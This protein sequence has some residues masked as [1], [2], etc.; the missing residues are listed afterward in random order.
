MR[1]TRAYPCLVC[2][3]LWMGMSGAVTSAQVPPVGEVEAPPAAVTSEVPPESAEERPTED[4]I[5]GDVSTSDLDEE[6]SSSSAEDGA[7]TGLELVDDMLT[8]GGQLYLRFDMSIL[9][10]QAFGEQAL[11][12]P[13]LLDIYL[14]ARPDPRLRAF[15]NGRLR[16]DPTVTDGEVDVAG[17]PIEPATVMLDQLWIKTDIERLVFFTIGQ[18]RVKWGACRVW[19]PTDFV[20]KSRRDPLTFFDERTGLPMI[21]LHV[22]FEDLGWNLYALML[23]D[24]VDS[25][26]DVG[27]AFR[28]EMVLGPAELSLS[29]VV[30]ANRKTSFGLDIS[31][32]VG[33]VDVFA[34]VA[35][36][37]EHGSND[38]V[39]DSGAAEALA[40]EGLTDAQFFQILTESVAIERRAEWGV[41]VGGGLEWSF[42]VGDDDT[43]VLGAEYF[44]NGLGESE[45]LAYPLMLFNGDFEALYVG[46]HYGAFFWLYPSPG[47]LDEATIM[48]TTLG[49][50]SDLTMVSR[51]GFSVSF[52]RRLRLESYVQVHYGFD[53]DQGE[54]RYEMHVPEIP[55][56]SPQ[57]DIRAPRASVGLNLRVAL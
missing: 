53:D 38:Y 31:A 56:V 40:D 32:G 33:D 6:S 26:K 29:A 11:A 34:E 55:D 39:V 48:F 3:I 15:V 12:M 10:D 28:L 45:P 36:S 23:F 7:T 9:D 19:N 43:M 18:Q 50:F 21:K 42:R 27:G 47:S 35:I 17:Q 4:E 57:L 51:V 30:G 13:N 49:N 46:E 37:D 44:Y 16:Y 24:G 5:F 41:R 25:L 20:N 8:I 22:P 2:V 14:D 1:S 54:L 52:H